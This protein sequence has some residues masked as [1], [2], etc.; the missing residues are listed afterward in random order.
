MLA[1]GACL[2]M[3]AW[4]LPV[5]FV[6][7]TGGSE[8]VVARDSL[9]IDTVRRGTLERS[10]A[11]AGKL[12]ADRIRIVATVADGIVS[13]VP[14]RAGARVDAGTVIARLENPDL[15]VAVADAA[16][17]LDASRAEV[18][19]ARE[20]AA[21]TRLDAESVL[22]T[23]RA[24]DA[25]AAVEA[26]AD[27]QLHERGLIGE[28]QYRSALIKASEDRDLVAIAHLKIAVGSSVADAKIAAAQARV[29]QLSSLL[30]ARRAQRATLVVRAGAAGIVE[31]VAVDPGQR[32]A[33]GAEFAR[34][35]GEHD[36]KAVLQVAESDMRG[37][38][39]GL[40]AR[41][42]A[43]NVTAI[44]R[45][46]RIAP[47]AQNGSVAVDVALEGLPPSARPDQNI[48]G[49]IVFERV[50]RALSVARPASA[51]DG[52]HVTMYRLDHDGTRVYRTNVSLGAGSPD[53]ARILSGLSAGD[54]VIVSDSSALTA[55]VIR[56]Q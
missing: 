51:I 9:V 43:G 8:P 16:A 14:V 36:L 22:R 25:R 4:A 40:R 55:P 10:V 15:D 17:Q 42:V 45:T 6:H 33:S 11:A 50:E 52:S 41:I 54:R 24:E 21:G 32:V 19:S 28:L 46:V 20:E 37:V 2:G 27:T 44:G 30:A 53:R 35:A 48:D 29:D 49:T 26:H 13:D 3:A 31:S 1:V 56:I 23:A 47:A 39:S 18:R 38:M 7:R 5:L 34:I 12:A